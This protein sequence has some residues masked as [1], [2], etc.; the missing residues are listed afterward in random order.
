MNPQRRQL[1]AGSVG[2]WLGPRAARADDGGTAAARATLRRLIGPDAD[3]LSLALVPQDQPFWRIDGRGAALRVEGHSPVALVRGVVSALGEAGR[4][5]VAWDGRRL[6]PDA[7]QALQGRQLEARSPFRHRVYLN[8]CTYGYTTAFWDEARWQAE[9][10]WMAAHGIDMPLAMEGQEIVWRAL[11]REQGLS[12]EE[13]AGYFSGPAFMPWQRMGNIEG[14]RGPVPESWLQD[15]CALQRQILARLRGLGMQPVLPGFAGYVPGALA[16]RHPQARIYRMIPWGG[17]RETWWL[18]PADPL[19]S[20]LSRRYL[21]LYEQ[22]YGPG[23]H[24]LVDAFNEMLPP[25]SATEPVRGDDGFFHVREPEPELPAERRDAALARYGRA[26]HSALSSARPDAVF[27]MQGWMFGFQQGFWSRPAIDAFLS[28]MPPERTLV[29]DLANDTYPGGWSRAGAFAG[30]PWVFG[31]VQ[32]FGGN[33]P[34]TGDLDLY[35]RDLTGL[36]SRNDTG[37][38]AGI[39][40]FPEGLHANPLV[41][42]YLLDQAWTP[43]D[44]PLADWLARHARSRYGRDDPALVAALVAL[45]DTFYRTR[46]WDAGWQHGFGTYLLCKRPAADKAAFSHPADLA[47]VQRVLAMWLALW[48]RQRGDALW[49]HDAVACVVHGASLWVDRELSHCI[50]AYLA[51][52]RDQGDALWAAAR[53]QLEDLDLLLGEMPDSLHHWLSQ[54]GARGGTPAERAYLV[55]NALAQVTVWGGDNVLNDYA[56]KAWQGLY[57]D[58]YAERWGLFFEAL[59]RDGPRLDSA[60][61][62]Q[63]LVAFDQGFVRAAQVPPLRRAPDPAA[64]AA[65]VLARMRA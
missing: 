49:T 52:E 10:D 65:R 12:D 25:V 21:D 47:A 48:P 36:A 23:R 27:V 22:T 14:Y 28:G 33:N 54:A 64:L 15:R 43:R 4:L 17:F 11:W 7:L 46:N 58:F 30:R 8:P 40:L 57:R 56:S 41:Y 19:F 55:D 2:L 1:L 39:G 42:A 31:Y 34:L 51:G 38:L 5:H 63:H 62:T 26:L 18:D 45:A 32:N 6:A 24:W 37:A 50:R 53:A 9:I 59:R 60:A 61:M 35:R 29:L 3:R 44:E 13:L 16:R 20:R